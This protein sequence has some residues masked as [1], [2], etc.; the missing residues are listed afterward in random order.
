M[1]GCPEGGVPKRFWPHFWHIPRYRRNT[2]YAVATLLLFGLAVLWCLRFGHG[3]EAMLLLAL[4]LGWLTVVQLILLSMDA[5]ILLWWR[6]R[7]RR[8]VRTRS[9]LP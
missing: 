5:G 1:S 6:K 8:A 9:L 2:R 3:D 7:A 4:L